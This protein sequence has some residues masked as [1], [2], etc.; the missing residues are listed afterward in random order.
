MKILVQVD[1]LLLYNIVRKPNPWS[2]A[3]VEVMLDRDS[4]L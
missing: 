1:C 2:Q 3:L 4:I